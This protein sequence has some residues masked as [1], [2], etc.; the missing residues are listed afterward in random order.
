MCAE[1]SL[2]EMELAIDVSTAATAWAAADSSSQTS[3]ESFI[4]PIATRAYARDGGL[5]PKALVGMWMDLL[6]LVGR[7]WRPLSRPLDCG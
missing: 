2:F 3:P 1:R 4:S 6:A 7:A 5:T